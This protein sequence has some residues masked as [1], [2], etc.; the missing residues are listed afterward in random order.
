[1][2]VQSIVI[3]FIRAFVI[4][5]RRTEFHQSEDISGNFL[6]HND[7]VYSP[8]ICTLRGIFDFN[9]LFPRPEPNLK[10]GADFK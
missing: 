4:N 1:M 2:F 10:K 9:Q 8:C 5:A 3:V 7:T 6:G